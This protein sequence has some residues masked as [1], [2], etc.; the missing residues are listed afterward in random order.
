MRKYAIVSGTELA[1]M[2]Y[3]VAMTM[4]YARIRGCLWGG[5]TAVIAERVLR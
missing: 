3:A 5:A 4:D 1:M 2:A